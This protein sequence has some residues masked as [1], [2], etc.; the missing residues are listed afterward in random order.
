MEGHAGGEE[1]IAAAGRREPAG[2]ASRDVEFAAARRGEDVSRDTALYNRKLQVAQSTFEEQERLVWEQL[3]GLVRDG[4]WLKS[5][6]ASSLLVVKESLQ[7]VAAGLG[8]TKQPLP[9]FAAQELPAGLGYGGTADNLPLVGG[10]PAV[11]AGRPRAA[12]AGEMPDEL[13]AHRGTAQP[14]QLASDE[15]L[16]ITG[17]EERVP[18]VMRGS[19]GTPA[20][21]QPRGGQMP[22]AGAR[23]Q[24]GGMEPGVAEVG[25]GRGAY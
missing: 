25:G 12:A 16:S 6:V 18:A 5:Y 10:M 21:M 3:S 8:P 20:S 17:R 2:A 14:L 11:R 13:H 23:E 19:A 4:A 7:G 24:F 1:R 9:G 15:A 22:A